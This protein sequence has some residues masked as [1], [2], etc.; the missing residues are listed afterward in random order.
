M[1]TY[2]NQVRVIEVYKITNQN[3]IQK[4]WI[5]FLTKPPVSQYVS[6]TYQITSS[7]Q[8]KDSTRSS[9]NTI[10]ISFC[11]VRINSGYNST[12][13]YSNLY[14]HDKCMAWQQ[15]YTIYIKFGTL[16]VQ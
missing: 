5:L 6:T 8:M 9:L 16:V 12:M 1:K 2:H 11:A 4:A 3:C 13:H 15:Y 14:R 7:Q 10:V